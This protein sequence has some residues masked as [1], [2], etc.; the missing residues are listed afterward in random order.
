MT[1]ILTGKLMS[2]LTL[3]RNLGKMIEWAVYFP[4]IV[5]KTNFFFCDGNS[6]FFSLL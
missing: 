2:D 4:Y 1:K 3:L 5:K 6:I